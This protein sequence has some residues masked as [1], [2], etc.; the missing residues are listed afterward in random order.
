MLWNM[1]V[2]HVVVGFRD[3]DVPCPTEGC[4]EKLIKGSP[5]P[6]P[7]P[8]ADGGLSGPAYCHSC[9][10]V[11]FWSYLAECPQPSLEPAVSAPPHA[12][13]VG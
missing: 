11:Y 6:R 8:V 7:W 9:D 2:N 10:D 5:P 13:S 12:A 1:A 4:E 3:S